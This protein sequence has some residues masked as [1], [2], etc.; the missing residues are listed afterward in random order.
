MLLNIVVFVTIGLWSSLIL[1][2]V[3]AVCKILY[4]TYLE[5]YSV[6]NNKNVELLERTL[7]SKHIDFSDLNIFQLEQYESKAKQDLYIKLLK[8]RLYSKYFVN[9]MRGLIANFFPK[10]FYIFN[11]LEEELSTV[12][13]MGLNMSRTE[14]SLTFFDLLSKI[15]IPEEFN[16]DNYDNS[17]SETSDSNKSDKSSK[18][19]ESNKSNESDGSGSD[20]S[21]NSKDSHGSNSS[22]CDSK[23]SKNSNKSN[24]SKNSNQSNQSHHSKK[25]NGSEHSRSSG[26]SVS[27]VDL[28]IHD[29]LTRNSDL[30]ADVLYGFISSF[31]DSYKLEKI[32][33]SILA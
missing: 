2:C 30:V 19:G 17:S 31:S 4:K 18:S 12:T 32:K 24:Q 29:T 7:I 10:Q 22:N 3:Y 27:S 25:S 15:K 13:D 1:G 20:S 21:N 6:E 14:L 26:N 9:G 8:N 23:E 5:K 11:D 33:Q 16:D 28:E